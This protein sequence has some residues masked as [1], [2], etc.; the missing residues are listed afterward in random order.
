MDL[1]KDHSER[2]PVIRVAKPLNRRSFVRTLAGGIAV[3]VPAFGVL[4]SAAPPAWA[5]VPCTATHE[6]YDGHSCGVLSNICPTGEVLTCIGHYT[7]YDNKLGIV[8]RTFTDDEGYCIDVCPNDSSPS[9]SSP[10]ETC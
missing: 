10:S 1:M 2:D 6:D 9:E 5:Y 8:C 4:A 3:A 7:V